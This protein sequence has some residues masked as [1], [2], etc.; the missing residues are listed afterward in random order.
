[1]QSGRFATAW[2][3]SRGAVLAAGAVCALALGAC[4][5]DD[6]DGGSSAAGTSTAA[7]GDVVSGAQALV[8]QTMGKLTYS[9]TDF[10]TKPDEITEYGDWRGPTSAPAPKEGANVQVIVCTK[11]AAACV[12][13][14]EGVQ[15]AGEALGWDVEVIDGGGTPQGF[16][17]A[18]DTAFS[19]NADAII[20][21]AVP[22]LAVGDKL[23]EAKSRDIV[24]VVTGDV[25]PD[26]GTTYD[27]YV[28]FRMPFMESLLAY[29]EIART[30]GK[31]NSIVVTDPSFPSLVEAM[32]QYKKVMET[33]DGCSTSDVSWKITDAAD[34]TKVNSI[35]SGALSKDPDATAITVPYAV[36][37][38][39]VIQAVSSAG[40]SEDVQVLVKD[41]DEVGLQAVR[42]G[43]VAYNAGASPTWAGWASVDQA[44]R[45][46]AGEDYLTPE[47]IGLG[48]VT[49]DKET[50]PAE[51]TID[52]WDGMIDY[53]AEYQKAWGIG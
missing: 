3:W 34:P 32:G 50:V 12:D 40:K 28:S 38:P 39:A 37:L 43:Q 30:D 36:G 8:D 9:E 20:G 22:T 14:A 41:G 7:A 23:E 47:Q 2:S 53:A 31:A 46:M 15:A 25:E 52:D 21:I 13:A 44:I 33:C 35:I 19:R 45:G 6:D 51:G 29:A 1:M 26:E 49:F 18:F 27:G 17:K 10:P 16:A 48:L 4:G 42:D 24:T 5:S 11:G